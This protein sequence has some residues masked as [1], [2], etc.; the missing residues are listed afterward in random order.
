MTSSNPIRILIADDHLVVR[1]G[2]K[3]MIDTQPGMKVVAEAANGREA[4]ALHREHQPDI[5]LMDL[6]MPVMSG[7][8]ATVAIREQFPEAH[9]MVLTIYDGDENIYRALQA[10][11]R[12]YLLKDIPGD[13]FLHALKAVHAGQYCIPPAVAARLAQ[14]VSSTDL[15]P[16]ELEILKRIA[17]GLSNK[18]IGLALSI[19]ESTVKNHVNSILSKLHVS[20][21]TQAVTTALRRGIVVLD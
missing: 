4:V 19:T 3:S 8:E 11:A 21:R 6:R 18:E 12:G 15:S 9:I 17:E 7:V 5:V 10:G 1:M 2:L 16:R 20:D 14:R 13:E